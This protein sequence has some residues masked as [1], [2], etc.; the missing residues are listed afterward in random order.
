MKK[1][2]N[3]LARMVINKLA[4]INPKDLHKKANYFIY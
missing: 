1:I 2:R 3:Y 4:K